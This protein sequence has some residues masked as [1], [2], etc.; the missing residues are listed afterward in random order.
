MMRRMLRGLQQ[1]AE[2]AAAV[3]SSD[4]GRDAADA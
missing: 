1:R 3:Q 2:Q 4:T